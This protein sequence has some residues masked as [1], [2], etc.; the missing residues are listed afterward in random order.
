MTESSRVGG[1]DFSRAKCNFFF[2]FLND[3]QNNNSVVWKK[4]PVIYL[5]AIFPSLCVPG[6]LDEAIPVLSFRAVA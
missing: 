3:E 6:T 5:L 4:S 1:N 2:S